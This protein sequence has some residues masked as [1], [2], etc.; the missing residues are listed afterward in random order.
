MRGL[1][2]W[3]ETRDGIDVWL[4]RIDRSQGEWATLSLEEYQRER[5]S[6]AFDDLPLKEEHLGRVIANNGGT[7]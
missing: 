2:R 6:P 4:A 7:S 5:I 1:Y 3:A